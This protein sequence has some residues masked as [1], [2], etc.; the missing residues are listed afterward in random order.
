MSSQPTV[1]V[2]LP[3]VPFVRGGAE[4]LADELCLRLRGRGARSDVVTVPFHWEPKE[5]VIGD[6]LAWRMLELEADMVVPLKFPSYFVRHPNKV[7]WLA[8]Q[9]RQLYEFHGTPLSGFAN[10]PP[11]HE[12]REALVQMDTR[13]LR[14]CRTVYTISGNTAARLKQYNGLEG[15]PLLVPPMNAEKLHCESY[16]DFLL[17]VGRLEENK[18]FDLLLRAVAESEGDFGV[19][20]AGTGSQEGNLKALAEELGIVIAPLHVIIEGKDY[21]DKIDISGAEFY[22]LLPKLNPLPTTSGVSVSDFLEELGYRFGSLDR[23]GV[24]VDLRHSGPAR[25]FRRHAGQRSDR[26][27]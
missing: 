27:Q 4:R 26:H 25:G 8:H 12:L 1:L 10:T 15:K 2:L 5:E 24:V 18:R 16:G 13:C 9:F 22:R 17:A 20:I 7:A 14:E 3:Q 23:V 11:D 21:R 19:R 6:A